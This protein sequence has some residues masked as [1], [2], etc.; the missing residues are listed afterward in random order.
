M[1][2]SVILLQLVH[3]HLR[4]MMNR[5]KHSSAINII[6][7]NHIHLSLVLWLGSNIRMLLWILYQN[8]LHKGRWGPYHYRSDLFR[9]INISSRGIAHAWL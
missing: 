1:T 6:T 8:L 2:C 7:N 9:L 5:S 3:A 4:L